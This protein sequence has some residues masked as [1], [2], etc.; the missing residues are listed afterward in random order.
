MECGRKMMKFNIQELPVTADFEEGL[1]VAR[2]VQKEDGST[3][4]ELEANCNQSMVVA[5]S[6]ALLSKLDEIHFNEFLLQWNVY[7]KDDEEK[8]L[9]TFKHT[10]FAVDEFERMKA[11]GGVK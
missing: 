7:C 2:R 4:I 3:R 11:E 1:L 6:V 8:K 9:A 10:M 5:V